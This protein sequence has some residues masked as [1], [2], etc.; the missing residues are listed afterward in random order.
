MILDLQNRL[1]LLTI[2]DIFNFVISINLVYSLCHKHVDVYSIKTTGYPL[3][4]FTYQL[5]F[6]IQ[7]DIM[8]LIVVLQLI[9]VLASVAPF[10]LTGTASVIGKVTFMHR[11][12]TV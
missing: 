11:L 9:C 4:V 10:E 12:Y 2:I 8:L 3:I 6:C 5:F 7:Y 1:D